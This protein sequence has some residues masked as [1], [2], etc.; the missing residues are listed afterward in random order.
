MKNGKLLM[1]QRETLEKLRL[2]RKEKKIPGLLMLIIFKK[3]FDSVSW[4]F[5]YEVLKTFGFVKKFWTGLN[6]S[7]VH[8]LLSVVFCQNRLTKSSLSTRR[9]NFIISIYLGCR[10]AYFNDRSK[11]R[12]QRNYI[13]QKQFK[14]TQL[15]ITPPLCLMEVKRPCRPL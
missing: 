6:F 10:N 15:Q 4:D 5:L 7:L 9:S 11:Y 2:C 8:M 1:N 13:P 14:L 12:Y 3:A